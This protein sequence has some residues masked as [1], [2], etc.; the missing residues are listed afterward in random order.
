VVDLSKQRVLSAQVRLLPPTVTYTITSVHWEPRIFAIFV[1]VHVPS[2][3]AFPKAG[4]ATEVRPSDAGPGSKKETTSMCVN[5]K[6]A[7]YV[8][9]A[10]AHL[11]QAHVATYRQ[12]K[13]LLFKAHPSQVSLEI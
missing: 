9:L 3:A 8:T 2:A 10:I 5:T 11:Y 7:A 13:K 4:L 12:R 1:R 6:E